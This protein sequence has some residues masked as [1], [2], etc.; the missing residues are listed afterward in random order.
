MSKR[1]ETMAFDT[2]LV[3]VDFT[4]ASRAAVRRACELAGEGTVHLLNVL[5]T[6][7]LHQRVYFG[8]DLIDEYCRK[9]EAEAELAIGEL[10]RELRA[11]GA[12]IETTVRRGR[13]SD[14]IILAARGCDLVVVGAHARDALGRLLDGS[15]AEEVARRS[16]T[17]TL[18]VREALEG[19][20]R[21]AR[22]LLPIDVVE[23]CPEAIEAGLALA[24]RLGAQL[25]AIHVI[26]WP[27]HLPAYHGGT[28]LAEAHADMESRIREAAPRAVRDVISKAIGRS[29]SIHVTTGSPAREII[30]YARPDDIIV[31]GSHGRGALGRL[32]FGSVATKLIRGAP[33]PVLVVR[34]DETAESSPRSR[35]SA[36]AS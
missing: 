10:A 27:I 7:V 2:I 36:H 28:A 20:S 30:G 31:C 16:T 8:H 18:V 34:P 17:P 35:A 25:E 12:R 15:V 21:V 33:C 6:D 9:L 32:A 26:P 4:P 3:G 11:G 23:P 29:P 14:E 5:D 1:N 24:D 13:P 22:I 19:S